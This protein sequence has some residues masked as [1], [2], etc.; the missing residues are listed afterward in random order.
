MHMARLTTAEVA[1]RLGVT[2]QT[3]YAYVSRGL[4]RPELADDGRSSTFDSTEVERYRA[5]RRGRR[6][7]PS[8]D[9]PI[10]SHITRIT[11]HRIFYRERDALAL[12]LSSPYELVAAWLI[13][14]RDEHL[15]WTTPPPL[16]A[17]CLRLQRGLPASTPL[18]ERLRSNLAVAAAHDALR[19]DLRPIAVAGAGAR[20]MSAMVD[21]LEASS[22]ERG[23][24]LAARLAV[25]LG[26]SAK[27]VPVINAALVLLAD[28]DLA[29]S[30]FAARVAAST[31]SHPYAVVSAGLGAV[32]GPLHGSASADV[33]RLLRQAI[34]QDPQSALSAAA[35]SGPLTGWG[36]S[37]YPNGDPRATVLFDLIGNTTRQ[38]RK[39]RVIEDVGA[40][41]GDRI[42]AAPNVDFALGAFCALSGVPDDAGAAIFA[43]A[44]SA[45]WLAHALEEYEE[46]PLRFRPK[47]NYVQAR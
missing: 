2:T 6:A 42:G 43:I 24:S 22:A 26:A 23:R 35:R 12:A 44:R 19:D 47:S 14:G 13:L 28:H 37:L 7:E 38:T 46:S 39:L 30:T 3:I 36:H 41:V 11:D 5:R 34:D 9:T 18:L 4:L 1:A 32:T 31:R 25:R 27:W 8:I 45:G 10:V 21:G 20:A 29:A 16:V 33:A 40:I 17:T 15:D